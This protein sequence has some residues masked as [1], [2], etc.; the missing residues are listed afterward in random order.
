MKLLPLI[1]L[2]FFIPFQSLFAQIEISG[3]AV[4]TFKE[5]DKHSY[6]NT[7][8]RGDDPFNSVRVR[9]FGRG[10]ISENVLI[11]T[12]FL[13]DM[14][15]PARIN[16]AYAVISHIYRDYLNLKVGMIPS[17]FGNFA[18]RSTYFNLN[19]LAGVPLMYHYRS[20]LPIYSTVSNSKLLKLKEEGYR[21]LPMAY[22]ACWDTGVEIFGGFHMVNYQIAFTDASISNPKAYENDG[23]Q[24]IFNLGV[25]PITGLYTG[26]SYGRGPYIVP[27]DSVL[28][29]PEKLENYLQRA[30]NFYFEYSHGHLLMWAEFYHNVWDTPLLA[31]KEIWANSGYFELRYNFY[32]GWYA[33]ARYGFMEF[34]KISSTDD[35]NGAKVEWDD[36]LNRLEVAIA[37]RF[38]REA[39]LRID[40]QHNNYA[41]EYLNDVNIL[42]VQLLL[43]F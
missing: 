37:Y 21:G 11:L 16:G 29:L 13:Y 25:N 8:F 18:L 39:F 9:L 27:P 12:E 6:I 36:G 7:N 35:G 42:A 34:S 26:V 14:G 38:I 22:E 30:Y 43:A 33:A 5:L 19:P 17:P 20:A 28:T 3:D 2:A 15:A 4:F 1:I 31:E 10:A 23:R 41:D 24:L 32:P 40:L